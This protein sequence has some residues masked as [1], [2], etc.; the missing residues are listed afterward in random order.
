MDNGRG[1][2]APS[3]ASG[4]ASSYVSGNMTPASGA[5]GCQLQ[6]PNGGFPGSPP[7]QEA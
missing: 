3:E 4:A 5:N 1:V 2:Q 7:D 6:S